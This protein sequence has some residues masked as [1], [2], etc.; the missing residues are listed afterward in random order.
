MGVYI[1][2]FGA[3]ILLI[4]G[5]VYFMW[6]SVAGGIKEESLKSIE[7]IKKKEA[8][9][10]TPT[11]TPVWVDHR[12]AAYQADLDKMNQQLQIDHLKSLGAAE[13]GADLSLAQMGA[14]V[15]KNAGIFSILIILSIIWGVF[16]YP[17]A[18]CVAA[19]TRSFAAVLNPSVGID[20]IHRMGFAEYFKILFMTLVLVVVSF[21][22]SVVL[23]IV[24]SPFDLPRMGNLPAIAV[25]SWFAYYFFVVF[26]LV[27]GFALYKNAEKMN[28]FGR[29]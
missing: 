29:R 7:M 2:C 1:V 16:Y 27:L 18:C 9:Y 21:A 8:K 19:Y 25:G 15:V 22:I 23:H 4:L 10:A 20:T 6:D 24:L 5:A 3:T 26:A 17:I 14:I 11:P 28:L 12:D 13:P